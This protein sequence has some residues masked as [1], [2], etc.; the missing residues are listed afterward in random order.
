MIK[1]LGLNK[2]LTFVFVKLHKTEGLSSCV[3]ELQTP[4]SPQEGLLQIL[5]LVF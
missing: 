2:K 5:C 4:R 1:N 3:V